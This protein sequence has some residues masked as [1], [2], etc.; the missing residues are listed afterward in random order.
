MELFSRKM[1]SSEEEKFANQPWILYWV[2][3]QHLQVYL[4]K[5]LENEQ[6]VFKE[7]FW[8][9][10]RHFLGSSKFCKN[11]AHVLNVILSNFKQ[12]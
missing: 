9:V 7:G 3:S 10:Q 6:T 5:S 11:A 4:E 12:L 2:L 8:S 1:M